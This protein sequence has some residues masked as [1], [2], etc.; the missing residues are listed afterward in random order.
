VIFEIVQILTE[1]VNQYLSDIGLKSVVAENAGFFENHKM[2]VP[3]N[4]LR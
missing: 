4:L 3:G 1:D 2:T